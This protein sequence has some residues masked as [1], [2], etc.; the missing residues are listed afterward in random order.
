MIPDYQSL[1]LPILKKLADKQ[2]HKLRNMN[3][4]LAQFII[5]YGIGVSTGNAYNVKKIDEDYFGEA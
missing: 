5:D 3:I 4:E 2:K 1:M